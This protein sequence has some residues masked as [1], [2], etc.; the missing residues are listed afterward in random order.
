MDDQTI[1]KAAWKLGFEGPGL[2]YIKESGQIEGFLH[3]LDYQNKLPLVRTQKIN[4]HGFNLPEVIP[5][6]DWFD[7]VMI[8]RDYEVISYYD[9]APTSAGLQRLRSM[10]LPRFFFLQPL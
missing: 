9:I 10:G 7:V 6:P 8:E 2:I 1:S 5:Y 3:T 4:K